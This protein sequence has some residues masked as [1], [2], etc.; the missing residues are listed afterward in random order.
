MLTSYWSISVPESVSSANGGLDR[1]GRLGKSLAASFGWQP[2]QATVFVLTGV[3][4][5]ISSVRAIVPPVKVRHE[6][7]L[8]WSRRIVLDVDPA[9]RSQEVVEAFESART[10]PEQR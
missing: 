8:D 1:L 9:A 2:A 7:A 6:A 3:P 10:M 5:L 4:P